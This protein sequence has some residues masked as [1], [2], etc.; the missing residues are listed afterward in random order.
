M[1]IRYKKMSLVLSAT[2]GQCGMTIKRDTLHRKD[3][4]HKKIHNS[5]KNTIVIQIEM[6]FCTEGLKC[7]IEHHNP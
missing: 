1:V 6:A 2:L 4:L 3:H 7:N 5:K